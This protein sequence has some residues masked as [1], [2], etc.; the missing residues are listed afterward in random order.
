[1]DA[2]HSLNVLRGQPFCAGSLVFREGWVVLTVEEAA[3]GHSALSIRGVGGGQEP[4][5]GPYDTA[6]REAREEIGARVEAVTPNGS[7]WWDEDPAQW[8]QV[9][10]AAV[11]AVLGL[12]RKRLASP[13]PYK[14]GLPGGWHLY[15]PVYL[16]TTGD[17]LIPGED[18]LAILLFP[19]DR[20]GRLHPGGEWPVDEVLGWGAQVWW[21]DGAP[22]PGVRLSLP[23]WE[24][25]V[26]CAA[27]AIRRGLVP[28][29]LWGPSGGADGK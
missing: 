19:P 16:T 25:M 12:G 6:L 9:R 13:E 11:P 28:K 18:Q 24:E 14:P 8:A 5:E 3:E 29:A 20:L 4:G 23:V 26:P 22:P 27:E 15:L 2:I 21:R 17:A 7:L 1:M 10:D